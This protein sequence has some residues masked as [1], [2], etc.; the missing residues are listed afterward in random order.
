[1]DYRE[2]KRTVERRLAKRRHNYDM[3]KIQKNLDSEKIRAKQ[4]IL[5]IVHESETGVKT[6]EDLP[7]ADGP[8]QEYAFDLNIEESLKPGDM[9]L[10]KNLAKNYKAIVYNDAAT[11]NSTQANIVDIV[12]QQLV[13]T[14]KK[15]EKLDK[16]DKAKVKDQE[17]TI[18]QIE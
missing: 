8:Q 2:D 12:F 17:E 10:D 18:E 6:K 9:A 5:K 7:T 4:R 15:F 14:P 16:E 3:N 11:M 13:K 1:M